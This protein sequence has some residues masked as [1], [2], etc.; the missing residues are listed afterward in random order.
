MYSKSAKTHA[1]I[2]KS[3]G[4]AFRKHGF[5]GASVDRLMKGAGLT[6]GGFYAHFQ[7]KE[8]LI[9]E[10]M[11]AVL[12]KTR[13]DLFEGLDALT[14]SDFLVAIAER[15]LSTRHRDG[16]LA[17]CALP[18]ILS[19]V[20]RSGDAPRAVLSAEVERFAVE[21]A[22]RLEGETHAGARG[23]ALSTL[24]VC[25]GGLMFARAVS[26]PKLSE[27]IMSSCRALVASAPPA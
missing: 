11:P 19:E 14:G 22:A 1:R 20:V 3:A 13:K 7:S 17:G 26:D 6:V 15:Y 12:S 21:V 8:A 16:V 18:A 9:A 10:T 5:L 2:L 24:A 4:E 23:R 27:E 25:V